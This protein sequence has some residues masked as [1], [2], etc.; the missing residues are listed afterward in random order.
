MLNC[1]KTIVLNNR[2]KTVNP[3][4][5]Y[6]AMFIMDFPVPFSL[7]IDINMLIAVNKIVS[8]LSEK[9][10]LILL[11]LLFHGKLDRNWFLKNTEI[12]CNSPEFFKIMANLKEYRLIANNGFNINKSINKNTPKVWFLTWRGEMLAIWLAKL[13]NNPKDYRRNVKEKFYA[14]FYDPIKP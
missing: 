11:E 14:F 3:I 6:T 10:Q 5:P 13:P 2:N 8:M 4:A 7:I 12:F 1:G 9:E